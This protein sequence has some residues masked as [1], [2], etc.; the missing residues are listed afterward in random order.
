MKFFTFTAA[1]L[2]LSSHAL[3]RPASALI[4]ALPVSSDVTVKLSPKGEGSECIDNPDLSCITKKDVPIASPVIADVPSE[5]GSA[6]EVEHVAA[7]AVDVVDGTSSIIKR[8]AVTT[9]TGAVS[10][11]KTSTTSDLTSIMTVVHSDVAGS[12]APTIQTT[13]TS[14]TNSLNSTILTI[15]TAVTGSIAP[16]V[17]AEAEALIVA[18]SDIQ[19]IVSDIEST[20]KATVGGVVAE[21]KSLIAPEISVVMSLVMP[22]VTPVAGFAFGVAGT[23]MGSDESANAIQTAATEVLGAAGSLLNPV[24]DVLGSLLK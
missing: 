14:I 11:L 6:I 10:T 13:L 15:A 4:K 17:P 19:S 7:P 5:V 16:V 2:T 12:I 3:A 21:T 9:I 23:L 1:A 22:L 8:S 18:L 20:L 24:G